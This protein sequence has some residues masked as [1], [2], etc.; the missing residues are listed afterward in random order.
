MPGPAGAAQPALPGLPP[1]REARLKV[2]KIAD[3]CVNDGWGSAT[4]LDKTWGPLQEVTIKGPLPDPVVRATTEKQREEG[5]VIAEAFQALLVDELRVFV[6]ARDTGPTPSALYVPNA[7]ASVDLVVHALP[8]REG[9]GDRQDPWNEL[10]P[11]R[12]RAAVDLKVFASP[13]EQ[14]F[15]RWLKKAAALFEHAQQ[16]ML[17][18]PTAARETR[19]GFVQLLLE[20]TRVAC[21]LCVAGEACTLMVWH[22]T[23][24]AT[25]E[26]RVGHFLEVAVRVSELADWR[27]RGQPEASADWPLLAWRRLCV[28][29]TKEKRGEEQLMPGWLRAVRTDTHPVWAEIK[30]LGD[31]G[32]DTDEEAVV[33]IASAAH[34]LVSNLERPHNRSSALRKRLVDELGAPGD[35]KRKKTEPPRGGGP[36][37]VPAARVR[38]LAQLYP[39]FPHKGNFKK[40]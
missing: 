8:L 13:S 21:L 2:G 3:L 24:G 15:V 1:V 23:P 22:I 16:E 17:K 28:M 10:R 40:D 35:K 9:V 34:V 7:S 5:L 38:H 14:D 27:Q 30:R 37:S 29:D 39:G 33:S 12:A 26:R 31:C 6:C 11:L 4:A 20:Y 36:S 25:L 32:F 19:S 18:V